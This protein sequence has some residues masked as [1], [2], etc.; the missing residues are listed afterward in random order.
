MNFTDLQHNIRKNIYKYLDFEDLGKLMHLNDYICNEAV[1]ETT[2][3]ITNKNICNTPKEE[4]M[5]FV[6]NN[7]TT[8]IKHQKDWLKIMRVWFKCTNQFK[9]DTHMF[10]I[11]TINGN[12]TPRGCNCFVKSVIITESVKHTHP[13]IKTMA[14]A[15]FYN[16]HQTRNFY[17]VKTSRPIQRR[18][19][20][21]NVTIKEFQTTTTF[22]EY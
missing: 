20:A 8:W 2:K 5:K 12:R 19:M 1:I 13:I 22:F 21:E 17:Y 6:T 7:F 18:K 9:I 11:I 3:R 14:R 4:I 10:G 15:K 16:S